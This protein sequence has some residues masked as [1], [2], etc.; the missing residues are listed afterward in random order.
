MIALAALLTLIVAAAVGWVV[1]RDHDRLPARTTVGGVDVGDLGEEDARRVVERAAAARAGEPII[2]VGHGAEFTV[3]GARLGATPLVDEALSLADEAGPLERALA[4]LGV[5]GRE[6]P[7]RFVLD[8]ELLAGF[9]DELD[10]SLARPALDARVR[11]TSSG[12]VTRPA[13]QGTAVNRGALNSRLRTLAPRVAVPLRRVQPKVTTE[14]A[15]RARVLAQALLAEPRVVALGPARLTIRPQ[16]LRRALRFETRGSTIDVA[17]DPEVIG[18]R[19]RQTW[20]GL[21]REPVDARFAIEGD[22]VTLFPSTHGR[23]LDVAGITRSLS[24]VDRRLHRTKLRVLRPALTTAEARALRVREPVSEFT[25]NYP[26]CAPRVSNIQRAA[27]ILDGSLLLPGKRFSLNDALGKRT[28][29]RGFVA[30]PQIFDGRLEEAVGGGVSQVAT[31]MYNAAFF[32]GLQLT[33][34]SPHQF[35][36]SRYP[37]GREATVSWGGPELIFKNDWPAGIVIKVAATD[38]SITVR[39]FS[40]KLR[41]RVETTTGRPYDYVQ[42]VTREVTNSKKPAGSR[43]QVQDAGDPGFSVDYTRKVWSGDRLRRNERWT[44]DYIAQDRIIEV[45]PDL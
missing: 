31:T 8:R 6:V 40:A 17:L 15:D 9:A 21:E 20:G 4:H 24:D 41:R 7:L 33:A 30:A 22:T 1:A 16:T 26:C 43:D 19:L 32:A 37:M 45:G 42:P 2:V 14:A 27:E 35:Y 38:T 39:F 18:R 3:T 11:V 44:V 13:A 25:T 36:I 12:L 5:G 10:A 28:K 23:E 34:H 29:A